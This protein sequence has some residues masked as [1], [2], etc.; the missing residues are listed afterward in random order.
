MKIKT[1]EI[2]KIAEAI[3]K[4][5]GKAT[6]RTITAEEVRRAS[7]W[8]EEELESLGLPKKT[9]IGAKYELSPEN[10]PNSYKFA[11]DSTVVRME[12]GSSG[13][14]VISIFRARGKCTPFG[15]GGGKWNMTLTMEQQEKILESNPLLSGLAEK[16][17]ELKR[18]VTVFL[19]E[20]LA[21]ES[22]KT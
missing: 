4:A 8:A 22:K 1:T 20:F 7:E 17:K 21:G 13:W 3:I 12:R 5:E 9:R 18:I 15:S 19:E 14:F 11:P 6:A 2:E 16:H 10:V